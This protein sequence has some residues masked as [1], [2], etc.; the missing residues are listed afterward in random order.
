MRLH[1]IKS[2]IF[3]CR[4][5]KRWHKKNKN[6]LEILPTPTITSTIPKYSTIC[7]YYLIF[8]NLLC[9]GIGSDGFCLRV[10]RLCCSVSGVSSASRFPVPVG[11]VGPLDHFQLWQFF[12]SQKRDD[13]RIDWV[14]EFGSTWQVKRAHHRD[15]ITRH[16]PPP[17]VSG[18]AWS[19]GLRGQCAVSRCL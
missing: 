4:N 2:C 3:D 5:T 14:S 19:F 18:G 16:S 1:R 7:G 11:G 9:S 8:Q 17:G 10:A 15:T 13:V 12:Y 6:G